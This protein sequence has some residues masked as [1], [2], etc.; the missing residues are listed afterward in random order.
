MCVQIMIVSMIT[1]FNLSTFVYADGKMSFSM[2]MISYLKK[3]CIFRILN[4][5]GFSDVQ[6]SLYPS[7]LDFIVFL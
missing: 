4:L 3:V 2:I 5:F 6:G 7:T 1:L